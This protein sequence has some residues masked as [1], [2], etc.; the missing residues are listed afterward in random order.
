MRALVQS[1]V[2]QENNAFTFLMC[3]MSLMLSGGGSGGWRAN[4]GRPDFLLFTTLKKNDIV[5]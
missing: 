1:S 4:F 3:G 2:V 5:G